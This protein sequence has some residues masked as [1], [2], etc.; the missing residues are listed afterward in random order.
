LRKGSATLL[1]VSVHLLLIW[2]FINKLTTEILPSDAAGGSG[3]GLTVIDLSGAPAESAAALADTQPTLPAMQRDPLVDTTIASE[4][5][6]PEWSVVRI[7]A[8]QQPQPM[9]IAAAPAQ[10]G[11]GAAAG[12]RS[13]NGGAGAAGS[14]DAPYDPFAGAAPLRRDARKCDAPAPGSDNLFETVPG[15]PK[16]NRPSPLPS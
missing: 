6:P 16:R 3:S 9:R 5:P 11:V 14:G 13:G 1:S 10:S 7:I 12:N 15:C 8:P 4:L 2:L